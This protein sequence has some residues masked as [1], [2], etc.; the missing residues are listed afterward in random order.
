[1]SPVRVLGATVCG[2]EEGA[3]I[4][5]RRLFVS[6]KLYSSSLFNRRF[7]EIDPSEYDKDSC[8][9]SSLSLEIIHV[10]CIRI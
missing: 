8:T 4:E 10:M 2:A 7:Q 1:M 6:A 3:A 5:N 9:S